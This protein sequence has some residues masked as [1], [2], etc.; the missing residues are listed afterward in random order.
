[1]AQP[2]LNKD[3]HETDTERLDRNWDELLQELRVTQTGVQILAGFLLT[4]PFQARFAGLE[5]G[6]T[7]AY[8]VALTAAIVATS[9]LVAPVSA[10]RAMFRRGAKAT[11]VTFADRAARMG[12][13]ALAVSITAAAFLIFDVVL[14]RPY[15]V[16]AA[17]AAVA[18]FVVNWVVVPLLV[19]RRVS[20]TET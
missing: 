4:L 3:R 12:L 5:T 17:C 1:M 19:R 14:G 6:Q 15:A 11:L 2:P 7:A 18:L 9:L 16:T 20:P 8:L 13:V 10:H